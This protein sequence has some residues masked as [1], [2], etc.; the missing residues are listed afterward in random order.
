MVCPAVMHMSCLLIVAIPMSC[1][2]MWQNAAREAGHDAGV[3]GLLRVSDYQRRRIMR[4]MKAWRAADG[5]HLPS[6][7]PD[8]PPPNPMVGPPDLPCEICQLLT[9]S[10]WLKS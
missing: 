10:C 4:H 7:P 8:M 3:E 1:Y 2:R 6:Q 5:S 9:W